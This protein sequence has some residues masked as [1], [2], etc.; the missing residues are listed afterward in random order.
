VEATDEERLGRIGYAERRL[1]ALLSLRGTQ[2]SALSQRMQSFVL[3]ATRIRSNVLQAWQAARRATL[4]PTLAFGK[5]ASPSWCS[6]FQGGDTQDQ[7]L[8][9]FFLN[10]VEFRPMTPPGGDRSGQYH[11]LPDA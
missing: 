8:L 9:Q 11:Q 6:R 10:V 3:D 7:N 2:V 4:T 1:D 5:T